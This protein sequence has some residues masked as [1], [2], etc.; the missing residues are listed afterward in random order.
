LQVFEQ[1][2]I[3]MRIRE[4]EAVVVFGDATLGNP[5]LTYV[6]GGTVARGGI[7]FK[8]AG[9]QP[10]LIVGSSDV[11][12]ARKIRKT[13]SIH[14]YT[15]HGLEKL[16]V[17]Y[18]HERAF[19]QFLANILTEERIKG[20]VIL[21]GRNDLASGINVADQLRKMG[22]KIRG[23]TSPT[24]L[25]TLRETKSAQEIE[26][27]RRVARK[28]SRTVES[29]LDVLRKL[30]RK[31]GH[32]ELL[33]KPAT[34]GAIKAVISQKLLAEHLR[35]P[36][37]T[38]FAQGASA[39]PVHNIGIPEEKLKER[40]LIIFDIYPQAETS[41][42]CDMTRSFVIGRADSRAK[43]IYDAVHEAQTETLDY[44]CE[45]VTGEEAVSKACD[46]IE[47]HGY[48]TVRDVYSGEANRISSG[49]THT[50]G[51]GVGLTIGERP[52]LTFG[53]DRPLKR[54]NVVTVEP[55]VYFPGYGGARIEDTVVITSRGIESLT[56]AEKELELT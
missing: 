35:E 20:K 51:H 25:E 40:K 9:E 54:G 53:N 47:R 16:T 14:T 52:H 13:G 17:K 48:R 45:G 11:E 36:E 31:R 10:F 24:L 55:G 6:V 12:T 2:D 37:G 1:F 26:E 18:G 32:L 29:V 22:F 49:L 28:T 5:D 4:I 19:T 34:V 56:E 27:L 30:K 39:I 44:L 46:I 42:W 23:E 21:S 33:G 50:L 3:E 8:R 7:F 41:Y 15:E 43:R 38:I